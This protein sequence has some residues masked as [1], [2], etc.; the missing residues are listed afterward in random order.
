MVDLLVEAVSQLLKVEA[1]KDL[2]AEEA[3]QEVVVAMVMSLS[4][5]KPYSY[6]IKVFGCRR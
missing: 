4:Y 5:F 1:E 2:P 6:T 3:N